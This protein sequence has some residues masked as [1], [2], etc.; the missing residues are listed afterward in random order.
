M[1]FYGSRSEL[2]E[3]FSRLLKVLH[4][5]LIGKEGLCYS[6]YSENSTARLLS[7]CSLSKY[8][9]G[10]TEKKEFNG[11]FIRSDDNPSTL[12]VLQQ[13][14]YKETRYWPLVSLVVSST[15]EVLAEAPRW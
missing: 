5:R 3:S 8:V 6:L 1:A 10:C 2:P 14:F 12:D 11:E 15:S 4:E 9:A 13:E 7:L